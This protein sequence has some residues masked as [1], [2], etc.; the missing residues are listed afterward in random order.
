[1]SIPSVPSRRG[2][3]WSTFRHRPGG[4]V[5]G[6]DQGEGGEAGP[7]QLPGGRGGDRDDPWGASASDDGVM[8]RDVTHGQL[9]NYYY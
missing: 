7:W 4:L 9:Q 5:G 2:R 8:G 6:E 1:M 3:S